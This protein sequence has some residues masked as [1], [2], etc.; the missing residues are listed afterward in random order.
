MPYTI[1]VFFHTCLISFICLSGAGLLMRRAWLVYCVSLK[2]L[3]L[4][5]FISLSYAHRHC[6]GLIH[7]RKCRPCRAPSIMA[8]VHVSNAS[9]T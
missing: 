8:C 1:G 6:L 2:G 7:L 5:R 3:I 4:I 9:V